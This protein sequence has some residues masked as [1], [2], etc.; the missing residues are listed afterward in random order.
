[1][2]IWLS[3]K[4][5]VRQEYTNHVSVTGQLLMSDCVHPKLAQLV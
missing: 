5:K 3:S 4:H 1:M 2:L